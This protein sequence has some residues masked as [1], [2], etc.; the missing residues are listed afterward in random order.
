MLCAHT[1]KERMLCGE[2]LIRGKL[3]YLQANKFYT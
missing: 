1:S 2:A 3:K